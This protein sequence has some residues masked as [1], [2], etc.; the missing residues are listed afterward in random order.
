MNVAQMSDFEQQTLEDKKELR[1]SPQSMRGFYS[2]MLNTAAQ[3]GL[4]VVSD[5]TCCKVL[6]W[7]YV[8]G[9]GYE[10]NYNT[11]LLADIRYAQKRLNV[12]GSE[13]PNPELCEPLRERIEELEAAVKTRS[14][15]PEW[16][17]E[18][19]ERYNLPDYAIRGYWK[20]EEK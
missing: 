7:L 18:L 11:K 13:I 8:Y 12:Y 10:V 20:G 5:D 19:K 1:S 17:L 9:G 14:P 6:A 2:A 3:C 15:S 4:K 16:L